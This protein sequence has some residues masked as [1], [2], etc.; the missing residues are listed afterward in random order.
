MDITNSKTLSYQPAPGVLD[1]SEMR[2]WNIVVSPQ[3]IPSEKYARRRVPVVV[4]ES[5]G[6][7]NSHWA[8]QFGGK[9]ARF[10]SV[11]MSPRLI[12]V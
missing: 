11:Q 9:P 4:R 12:P 7:Y 1:C 3:A 8:R 10:V 2:G 5:D 6:G